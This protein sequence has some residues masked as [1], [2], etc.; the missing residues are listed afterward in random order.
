MRI[1]LLALVLLSA[2]PAWCQAPDDNQRAIEAFSSKDFD[3]A[4]GLWKQWA[5]AHPQS[6]VPWYNMACSRSIRGDTEGAGEYLLT[7]IE[8]GFADLNRM[9]TDPNLRALRTTETYRKIVASWPAF[10]DRRIDTDL[11]QARKKY[12]PRYNYTKDEK[13]RLAFVSAYDTITSRQA[14]E[15]VHRTA[16]WAIRNV[17]PDLR[18]QN[19]AG[20]DPWVLVILPTKQHF[21]QWAVQ[22]YG[23]MP[24]SATSQLGGAYAHDQKQLVTQ[25]LGSTLRH[26][27]FHVMHWRSQDRLGQRHPVWIQ[28]GL[29]S[30]VEDMD[31]TDRGRWEPAMSW[32][33]N[34]VA[35]LA[36]M[37][38]LIPIERL[39]TMSRDRFANNRALAN[40]AVSRAVFMFLH[41]RGKLAAFYSRYTAGFKEDP[42]GMTALLETLGMDSAE[43]F[44]RAIRMWARELPKVYEQNSPPSLGIGVVL[45]IS[46][47]D[48]PIVRQVLSRSAKDAGLRRG[49]ILTGMNGRSVR[50]LNEFYR[51]L[52]GLR[53]GQQIE[54]TYRRRSQHKRA[55]VAVVSQPN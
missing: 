7:A 22:T 46:P 44:D 11:E 21:A 27:F 8:R 19:Q 3:K 36:K 43:E 54:V 9:Q 10:L 14:R 33:T 12:G 5:E 48:G 38:K 50:D 52:T 20:Q 17:F 31:Q 32:R 24:G 51:V 28:E 42:T 15:E 2:A 25:D 30:L 26:E 4:E 13:Y 39:S 6:F 29:A 23:A 55:K 37:N 16:E 41:D 40:Y 47:G 18:D 49:D 34:T 1:V 45:D 53:E 35:R